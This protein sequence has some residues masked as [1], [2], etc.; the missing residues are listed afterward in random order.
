MPLISM[1]KKERLNQA[2]KFGLLT[3]TI[4]LV[5]SV[6]LFSADK[7]IIAACTLAAFICMLSVTRLN[8]RWLMPITRLWIRFGDCLHTFFSPIILTIIYAGVITPVGLLRKVTTKNPMS[9]RLNHK[10]DSYWE[11]PEKSQSSMKDQF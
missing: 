2:S 9:L 8:P 3:S 1:S 4:L 7:N 11:T 10:V 6:F 5:A